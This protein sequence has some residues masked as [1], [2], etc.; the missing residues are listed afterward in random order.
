MVLNGGL[1]WEMLAFGEGMTAP[2]KIS[3]FSSR[4]NV[5]ECIYW[6]VVSTIRN[7]ALPFIMRP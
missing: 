1:H 3:T 5:W 4:S 2:P 7:R 6:P